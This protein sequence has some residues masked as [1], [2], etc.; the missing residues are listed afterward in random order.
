MAPQSKYLSKLKSENIELYE[1]F[2]RGMEIVTR[3]SEKM[4]E[5]YLVGGAVR[6]YLLGEPFKDIDI[7]TNATP[8]E[9]L[10]I[11]PDAD[12]TF[13]EMGCIELKENG[14]TFQITTFRD[15]QLVTTRKTKNIHYSK[16]L[17][18]D[19]LR[20]DFT[21]NALA[22]TTNYNVV[23]IVNGG[24]DLKK[25]IVRV[26]G[27]P[28]KRFR[29][30]SLRI[31]RGFELI[32]RYNF[33]LD[34]KTARGMRAAC[35]YL[36]E[37]S[38]H[39]QTEALYKILN[40]KYAR[41]AILEMADLDLFRYDAVYKKW[42]TRIAYKFKKTNV[43]EKFA[44]LYYMYGSIPNNTC[45]NHTT[46]SYFN[47]VISVVKML[48]E[49]KVDPLM[50]YK[51]GGEILLSANQILITVK[52]GYKNQAKQIKKIDSSLVIRDRR[53]LK[54]TSEELI[55][56]LGNKSSTKITE[57]M[58][59]IIRKV[60]NEE[61]PNS[62]ALI[63][64]EVMRLINLEKQITEEQ[65]KNE[66]LPED[67]TSTSSSEEDTSQNVNVQKLLEMYNEEFKQLY[68]IYMRGVDGFNE[69]SEEEQNDIS[70]RVK[71]KVKQSL[72]SNNAKY[73]IL[74]ERN[75]I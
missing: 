18:D 54:F 33:K 29:E 11:F 35:K 36:E 5:A 20:R 68:N 3:L 49:N 9:I 58:D 72:V 70:S 63:R 40:G 4:Y 17:T 31:Y 15:E 60:I 62:N 55:L 30:D 66:E 50:V 34:S 53:D 45:F 25:K 7:A 57:I 10:E 22:L 41:N 2:T 14:R 8:R 52:R 13:S 28:K 65:I 51:Y 37:V 21:V 42:L 69:M 44:S 38:T 32:S 19:V 56:M 47:Q 73:N 75:M 48:E 39:K 59:I 26:I 61:I 64:Q 71:Q 24:K 46:L 6:D 16:K 1:Y 23:D 12:G 27:K 43:L 74:V 67:N